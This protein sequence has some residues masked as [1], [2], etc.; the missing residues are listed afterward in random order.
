MLILSVHVFNGEGGEAYPTYQTSGVDGPASAGLCACA[1][2][3]PRSP[4]SII[5]FSDLP[6]QAVDPHLTSVATT[7]GATV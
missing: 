7:T 2:K 3:E 1:L 5:R 6:H 4:R